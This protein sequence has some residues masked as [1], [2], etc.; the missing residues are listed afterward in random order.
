ML[1]ECLRGV[2]PVGMS[3]G[4]IVDAQVDRTGDDALVAFV[5]GRVTDFSVGA[6]GTNVIVDVA[7]LVVAVGGKAFAGTGGRLSRAPLPG[8]AR[9]EPY[10]APVR[11][12]V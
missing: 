3:F 6:G 1:Y 10:A 11:P 12:D 4:Y 9:P 7:V 8:R 5:D 2:R